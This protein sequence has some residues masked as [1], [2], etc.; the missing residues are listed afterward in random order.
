[1]FDIFSGVSLFQIVVT[2][3]VYRSSKDRIMEH[4]ELWL[5]LVFFVPLIGAILYWIFKGPKYDE[6]GWLV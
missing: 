1:M 2:Y 5:V 4:K 3:L 6:A